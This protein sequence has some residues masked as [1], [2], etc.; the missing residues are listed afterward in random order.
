[1]E[2]EVFKF[3]HE[4]FSISDK[5]KIK[6]VA[7]NNLHKLRAE[8][9]TAIRNGQERKD[10]LKEE[11]NKPSSSEEHLNQVML[12]A[13]EVQVTSVTEELGFQIISRSED[14]PPARKRAKSE[15]AGHEVVD[16]F[17]KGDIVLSR[18]VEFIQE[19]VGKD[20]DSSPSREGTGP[21]LTV[22]ALQ[23][24]ANSY[25]KNKAPIGE[26]SIERSDTFLRLLYYISR[27]YVQCDKRN[28]I[29]VSWFNIGMIKQ[30]TLKNN[31][32]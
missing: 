14:A 22:S 15:I 31:I 18:L 8:L 12:V 7:S 19:I 24:Q 28:Q 29:Y 20:N 16:L 4:N 26:L 25:A 6:D 32:T 13:L 5:A 21:D 30:T 27:G 3:Y 23:N 2:A 9:E 17:C 10:W 11:M 1:V